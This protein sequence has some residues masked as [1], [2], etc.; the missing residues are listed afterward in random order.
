MV[1]LTISYI[2]VMNMFFIG[3]DIGSSSIKAALVD[4]HSNTPVASRSSP[5]DSE[6]GMD[7]ARP[8]WAEQD[9]EVWWKNICLATHELLAATGVNPQTIKAIGIAYQMHGLVLVDKDLQSLRSSIIWCDS[10]A[11]AIG[12]QAFQSLG[13]AYCLEHFLNSPGNFTASKLKWVKENEPDLF[14]KVRYFMLP[15]DYVTLRMTGEVKTTISGLSEGILWDF[16]EQEVAAR[17]LDHHGI[18]GEILPP[19]TS[20]LGLQGELRAASAKELG[21]AAGTPITYR[22]GDQP[23]NA[24]SLGV[25]NP[26]EVAATGGTSGVVYGVNA[27]P[28]MDPLS[29]VNSFAHVNYERERPLTGILLCINGAG[30]LFRWLQQQ[31]GNGQANYSELERHA[32]KISIGA[33]GL[34]VLPFGNGAER[35]LENRDLGASI[36]GLQL[37]RHT[38]SHVVRAGLEGIAFGFVYGMKILGDLGMAPQKLRVGNDNL[39]QSE[40]FSQTIANLNKTDIEVISNTGAVGA[41]R[42]AGYGLGFYSNL[43]EAV[44][45][46]P[47]IKRYH[48]SET[49]QHIEAYQHWLQALNNRIKQC[50]EPN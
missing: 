17:M 7:T 39:F 27:T 49:T 22:A 14:S 45:A 2:F 5:K 4:G 50:D 36:E 20:T 32:Q 3:Y 10:R 37:N 48:P 38:Q 1:F 13:E 15:G 31:L 11:V 29:R 41:A 35:M 21:L 24:L 30:I 46:D 23:N 25:L 9:P 34:V 18:P 33:D 16:K 44:S 8:G 42:A 6:L 26:G 19:L 40:I 43:Q 47:I 12:E 28:T